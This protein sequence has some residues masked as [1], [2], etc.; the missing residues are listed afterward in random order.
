MW[1]GT[2][3]KLNAIILDIPDYI[4]TMKVKQCCLPLTSSLL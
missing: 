1:N 4:E 3:C 2:Q